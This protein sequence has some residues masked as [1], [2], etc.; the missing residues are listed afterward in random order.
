MHSTVAQ[1]YSQVADA[2]WLQV[3]ALKQEAQ[4]LQTGIVF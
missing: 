4:Q 3:P 2:V 1:L